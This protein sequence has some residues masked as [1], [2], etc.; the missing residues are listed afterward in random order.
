MDAALAREKPGP[1]IFSL[2]DYRGLLKKVGCGRAGSAAFS[3]L[4]GTILP[5]LK[6]HPEAKRYSSL[7]ERL[8]SR[9]VWMPVFECGPDFYKVLS[10][11]P[12]GWLSRGQVLALMESGRVSVSEFYV[13]LPPEFQR[14]RG[15]VLEILG[16]G[17]RPPPEVL[18]G[19]SGDREIVLRAVG[20]AGVLL[21]YAS[22]E[23]RNDREVVRAAVQSEDCAIRFASKELQED[24][25][26]K[27]VAERCKAE[28][29]EE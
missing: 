28:Y 15:F 20:V 23:L 13:V 9:S 7:K 22:L 1:E 6:A 27:T 10:L 25:E 3:I 26:F 16:R 21:R 14:D 2:D 17:M 5:Y 19:F 8:Y 29:G 4:C 24:E 18:A 11:L 12:P